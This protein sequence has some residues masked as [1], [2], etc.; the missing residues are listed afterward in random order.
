MDR[1]GIQSLYET[2]RDRKQKFANQ[3]HHY[4]DFGVLLGY[5]FDERARAE[6]ETEILLH[7]L[8]KNQ[9]GFQ[10]LDRYLITVS[11][12]IQLTRNLDGFLH[13]GDIVRLKWTHGPE[14]RHHFLAALPFSI[15]NDG[16]FD[17]PCLAT[18]TEDSRIAA[19][20]AFHVFRNDNKVPNHIPLTYGECI[21]ICTTD[22]TGHRLLECE[23]KSFST[24][25]RKSGHNEVKW[26]KDLSA[27]SLWKVLYREKQDR[28]K[29]EGKFIPSNTD[30]VISH[31][32]TGQN[33]ALERG[34]EMNTIMGK[35]KE[36]S[37]HIY[38]DRYKNEEI[39]NIWQFES[40]LMKPEDYG[41]PIHLPRCETL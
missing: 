36:V 3:H 28:R 29:T 13:H 6:A 2:S 1:T 8:S 24:F 30:V 22:G 5:W 33:L 19:R 31:I 12:P 32:S 21:M 14:E 27:R 41:G 34:T 23:P 11:R 9:L 4:S 25:A 15:G 26:V 20:T 18:A 37:G 39:E 17:E 7:K 35:E 16:T 38:D 10:K 40:P